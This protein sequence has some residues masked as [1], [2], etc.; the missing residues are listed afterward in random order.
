MLGKPY[1]ILAGL[2]GLIAIAGGSFGKGAEW[3]RTRAES[4][5]QAEKLE[6]QQR[7]IVERAALQAAIDKRDEEIRERERRGADAVIKVRT[8]YLPG[9]VV[10]KR[11]VVERAV[12]RDC[13]VGDG[14]RA[15]LNAALAGKPV[16]GADEG[17]D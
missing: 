9:K 1:L 13:H 8:E 14:M 12:F 15:T 17:S 2:I 10:V 5:C 16:P 6:A 11:E 3:G 4:A 7:E